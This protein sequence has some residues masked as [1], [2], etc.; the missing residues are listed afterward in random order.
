MTFGDLVRATG[1]RLVS[2]DASAPAPSFFV[3]SRRVRPGEIFAAIKGE[4]S[5]GHDFVRDVLAHGAGGA[6][7]SRLPEGLPA[8]APVLVVS[9]VVKALQDAA[10]FHRAGSTARV[11]G[12]TGSNGKTTTKEMISQVL[13]AG[14]KKV[15]STP[16]NFNSQ[17]GLPLSVCAMGEENTHA[18]FEMGA[19]AKGNIAS[20]AAV[21][22]PQIGV[23]TNIGRAHL[24]T[25]GTLE[26]TADAKWEL[27][28][29]LPPEGAAV[30]NADDPRLMARKGRA[31][32]RVVT[33]GINAPADVRA[34]DL[35]SAPETLF[36]LAAGGR[37]AEVRLPV[38]GLFNAYNALAAAAVGINEGVS[39]ED[40]VKGLADFRPPQ[41]RM[42]V[43]R[44]KA[45]SLFLIDAYNANP[46]SMKAS[47]ES[48]AAAYPALRRFAVLGGMRELGPS[49]AD[50]HRALGA[51]A[52][53][54][55]LEK[56]Y[57]VGEEGAWVKEGW[58]ADASFPLECVADK[59]ALR[60]ILTPELGPG[61]AFLFKA[62][63]G[64]ALEEVYE[65]LLEA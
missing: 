57:F 35:R 59:A 64:V 29:A 52:S 49:A 13:A 37:R 3:D 60:R 62:S 65:P 1:G 24:L 25:F 14:G 6:L 40:V 47:L 4:R 27:V 7:V 30:I 15:Y 26:G 19:S 38:P 22:K 56:L 61:R 50:E 46:D 32:S 12:V 31:R 36:T 18:V 63:R 54:M 33:Y 9:D 55:D 20:L 58:P 53:R 17:I 42:Q 51:A 45:G 21:A 16:G 44:G 8:G 43:R 41:Q 28:D 23:L 11:V 10:R 2:G 5:D 34:E 39:L 48:F